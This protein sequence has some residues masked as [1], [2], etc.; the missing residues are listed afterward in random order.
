M[1]SMFSVGVLAELQ[2][3]DVYERIKAVYA[4]SAGVVVAAYFLARQMSETKKIYSQELSRTLYNPKNIPKLAGMAIVSRFWR[5]IPPE[6]FPQVVNIDAVYD[7][8]TEDYPLDIGYLKNQPIPLYASF[9]NIDTGELDYL[10]VRQGD[11]LKNIMVSINAAPGSYKE[12]RINGKRYIDG[13]I[14]EPFSIRVVRERHPDSPMLMIANENINRP[15]A[16]YLKG[17]IEGLLAEWMLGLPVYE[18]YAKREQIITKDFRVME[19]DGNI[20][21]V[22]LPIGDTAKRYT[23]DPKILEE[24]YELGAQ[25]A[26]EALQFIRGS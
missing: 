5:R 23:T 10:D 2:K 17:A 19:N 11:T 6:K 13:A 8:I 25:K 16:N 21:L 24:F 22:N 4:G 14:K 1:S 9:L 20:R 26:R 12:M 15:L 18:M 7:V 3:Q